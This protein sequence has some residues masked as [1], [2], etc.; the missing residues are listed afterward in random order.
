[1]PRPSRVEFSGAIHHLMNRGDRQEPVCLDDKDRKAFLATLAEACKKTGWLVHACVLL[2]NHDH[3]LLETPEAN[4]VAG[5]KWL[6]GTA[7]GGSTNGTGRPA[8]CWPG[9]GKRAVR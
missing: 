9:G 4:R 5:R 2:G 3:L 6:E 1:M 8:T 7:R